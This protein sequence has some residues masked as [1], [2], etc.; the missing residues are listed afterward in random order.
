VRRISI[1][2]EILLSHLGGGK[3]FVG[4]RLVQLLRERG[5]Q[6]I[7]IVSRKSDGK[8][9]TLTW[10]DISNEWDRMNESVFVM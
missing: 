5:F 1:F 4:R 6:N 2:I 8:G 3:G 9:N 10:V 7:W